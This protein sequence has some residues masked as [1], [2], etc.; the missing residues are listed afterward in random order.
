MYS[1]Y[2]VRYT[3]PVRPN[4]IAFVMWNNPQYTTTNLMKICQFIWLCLK[5]FRW[6]DVNSMNPQKFFFNYWNESQSLCKLI[7]K[8]CS[9]ISEW[10]S[11]LDSLS[12]FHCLDWPLKCL[13][14]D[15]HT[16]KEIILLKNAIFNKLKSLALKLE[17][18]RNQFRRSHKKQRN[19]LHVEI[20][21][22]YNSSGTA[23]YCHVANF[24]RRLF[25]DRE[26]KGGAWGDVHCFL[27]T[28]QEEKQTK[29]ESFQAKN[30]MKR[31]RVLL[32]K[33]WIITHCEK[34]DLTVIWSVEKPFHYTNH[35]NFKR[36]KW[37]LMPRHQIRNTNDSLT[38]I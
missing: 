21:E 8:P 31:N 18:W 20:A 30:V 12:F 6:T 28:I 29:L 38:L 13:L 1:R 32:S 5:A 22:A 24:T 7:R 33:V 17:I 23:I 36:R 11:I 34:R 27:N 35:R 19:W 16:K 10:A 4:S 3:K 15:S 26:G 2:S 14:S 9:N 37:K 25:M